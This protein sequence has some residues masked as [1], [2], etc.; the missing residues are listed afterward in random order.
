MENP[1]FVDDENIPLVTQHDEDIYYDYYN[2]P[3]TSRADEITFT[4]PDTTDEEATSTVRLRH[5]V[6]RDKLAALYKY[7][8]VTGNLNVINRDQFHY[9]KSTKKGTAILEFCNG[10][11]WVSLTKK[12]RRVSYTKHA[13]AY[14]CRAKCN[15]SFSRH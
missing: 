11:K 3:D 12:N 14:F 7:L 6:K 2:T 9:T 1:I 8:N 10:D 15:E 13:E 5:K 4:T